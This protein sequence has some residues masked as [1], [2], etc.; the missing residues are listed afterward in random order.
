M[1]KYMLLFSFAFV[2]AATSNAN[3][4]EDTKQEIGDVMN[5]TVDYIKDLFRDLNMGVHDSLNYSKSTKAQSEALYKQSSEGEV[6]PTVLTHAKKPIKACNYANQN[7]H[8]NGSSWDCIKVNVASDC[9]PA[10]D[11]YR[12]QNDNGQWV[13][14][15]VPEGGKINGYWKFIDYKSTCTAGLEQEK[16]Y[17]CFYK[18]KLGEEIQIEESYCAG[19]QKPAVED[20]QCPCDYETTA[21]IYSCPTGYTVNNEMC[22]HGTQAVGKASISCPTGFIYDGLLCKKPT[23]Y[24]PVTEV[25][26]DDGFNPNYNWYEGAWGKCSANSC[27]VAGVQYRT[28]YCKDTITGAKVADSMCS[29]FKPLTS[30]T[31]KSQDCTAQPTYSCSS[32]YKLSGDK[33]TKSN[34]ECRYNANNRVIQSGGSGWCANNSTKYI[35]DGKSYSKGYSKGDL[36]DSQSYGSCKGSVWD[37]YYEICGNATVTLNANVTCPAGYTYHSGTK[38]CIK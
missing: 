21:V 1:K 13:C 16:I 33:C 20:K 2:L 22:Y 34:Y 10:P 25:K 36:K 29:G 15:K 28:V 14:D 11:E 18:N 26:P 8:W 12:Y 6:N 32:G 19:K 9:Q 35:W 3:A 27:G 24:C 4:L 31:C 38:L 7:L 23:Q 30:Q 17:G 37:R 5:S